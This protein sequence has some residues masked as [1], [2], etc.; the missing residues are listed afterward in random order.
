ME[1]DMEERTLHLLNDSNNTD[2]SVYN[3]D[4][5]LSAEDYDDQFLGG[6]DLIRN[7]VILCG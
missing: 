5:E 1:S 2:A 3:D 4:Y 7:N 6:I